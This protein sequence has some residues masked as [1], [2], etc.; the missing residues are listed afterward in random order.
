MLT[1]FRAAGAGKTM[2]AAVALNHLDQ[3]FPSHSDIKTAGI[4]LDYRQA[5]AQTLENVFSDLLAQ[6]I[7]CQKPLKEMVREM[8]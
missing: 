1:T 8:H 5:T 2:L 7:E 6:L 4:Y 3:T